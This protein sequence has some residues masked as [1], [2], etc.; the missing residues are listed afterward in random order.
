MLRLTRPGESQI[1][2]FLER[3]SHLAFTYPNVGATRGT[4][5]SGYIVNSRRVC[6]GSGAATFAS[7]RDALR[8][9]QALATGW[10]EVYPRD[11]E[12]RAG[13]TVAVL[14][15]HFPFWSLNATR[16]VYVLDEE[17]QAGFAYGTLP[18]HMESG[19]E[20][21]LIE[22]NREDDS[23]WYDLQAF[24]RWRHPLAR[25]A[26]PLAR[27]VVRRFARDSAAAMLRAV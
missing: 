20:R 6:L 26:S 24:V 17:A 11:A 13:Q 22:W 4:P 18:G 8:H 16:V 23:V 3:Q 14:G 12:V 21:F 1:Q 15:R 7:A 27:A 19:E 10:T 9:W 25:L 5:P 2:A